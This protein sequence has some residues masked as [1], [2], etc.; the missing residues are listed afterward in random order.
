MCSRPAAAGRLHTQSGTTGVVLALDALDNACLLG[1]HGD[2]V[3]QPRSAG[4]P[5]HHVPR[6]LPGRGMTWRASTADVSAAVTI[7]GGRDRAS[8]VPNGGTAAAVRTV[9]RRG[10]ASGRPP[11]YLPNTLRRIS[12]PVLI[13][14]ARMRFS[15]SAIIAYKPSS[16]LPVT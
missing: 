12:L 3:V 1:P 2:L 5:C 10:P 6:N 11:R 15:S 4:H 9:A 14:S 8:F 7:Q 16:D 13:G